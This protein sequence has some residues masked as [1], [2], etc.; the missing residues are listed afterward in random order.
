MSMIRA[1]AGVLALTLLLGGLAM[2]AYAQGRG[3]RHP[4]RRHVVHRPP[5][6]A[7]GYAAPSYVEAPPP[8]VYAPPAPPPL[9]LPV[10]GISLNVN[11]P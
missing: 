7:W 11:I 8:V 9:V 3:D 1:G 2:P 10:P 4:V 5:R 6:P